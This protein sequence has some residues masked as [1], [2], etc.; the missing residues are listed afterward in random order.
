VPK[1]RVVGH[2]KLA[3]LNFQPPPQSLM[4]VQIDRVM[5][6]G[7]GSVNSAKGQGYVKRCRYLRCAV[8]V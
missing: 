4:E 5:V 3:H 2:L 6:L 1:I 8:H 7:V